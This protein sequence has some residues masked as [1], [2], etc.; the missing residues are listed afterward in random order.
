MTLPRGVTAAAPVPV[1]GPALCL[2]L[3]PMLCAPSCDTRRTDS[4][5]ALQE[6]L[7]AY[8]QG[9]QTQAMQRMEM[10][11]ELD[12]TNDLAHYY[13]GLLSFHQFHDTSAAEKHLRRAL[14]LDPAQAEYQYQYAAV[15]QSK[16]DHAGALPFIEATITRSPDHAEARYRRGLARRH[17]G[18]LRDAAEDFGKAIELSPRF[19]RAYVELADL[20]L[21]RGHAREAAQVLRNCTQNAPRGAECFNEYGRA[22]MVTGDAA[23]AIA[24]FGDSLARRPDYPG[25]L[26]NVGMAHRSAGDDQKAEF[27]LDRYLRVADRK[28]EA[29]RVMAAEQIVSGTMKTQ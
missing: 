28:A 6:G 24:A 15:I 11:V 19:D 8:G 22:L 23:G 18:R 9:R 26:F 13:V 14:D 1:L 29:D 12:D 3:A 21:E 2:L 4:L 16:G 5:R 20:Y 25:A 27:Y 7:Q 17:A 10:A